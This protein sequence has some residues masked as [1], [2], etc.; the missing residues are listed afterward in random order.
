M[1]ESAQ[2]GYIYCDEAARGDHD[3]E[4]VGLI[5]AKQACAKVSIITPWRSLAL[6]S[7]GLVASLFLAGPGSLVGSAAA[8][9]PAPAWQITATGAPSVLA[10]VLGV[11]GEF[12][13]VVENVGGSDSEGAVVVK[14]VLP[15]GLTVKAVRAVPEE[16]SPV[17]EKAGGEVR[18]T[19]SGAVVPSGFLVVCIEYE[20]TGAVSSLQNLVEVSGGGAASVTAQGNGTRLGAAGETGP[21]GI[22]QF[23]SDVTDVAGEPFEQAG[24]HP[25]LQTTSLLFNDVY[26]EGQSRPTRSVGPVK[27]IVLYLPLGMLDDPAV[28]DPCPASV[29]ETDGCPSSGRVGSVLPLMGDHVEPANTSDST[30]VSALYSVTP[31]LGNTAEFAFTSSG[32]TFFLYA[33]VVRHDGQYVLSVSMPDIPGVA[34]LT[35]LIATFYGDLP[36]RPVGRD[37][38]LTDPSDCGAGQQALAGSVT[39]NTWEDPELALE[40]SSQEFAGIVGCEELSFQAGLEVASQTTQAEAPAGYTVNLTVPQAPSGGSGLATPPIKEVSVTLPAGTS[41]SPAGAEELAT[42]RETGPSGM[43]IEDS[44]SEEVD[45]NGLARPVAGHCPSSSQVG[46]ASA[47]TPLLGE[48]LSGHLFLAEPQCGGP[49]QRACGEEDARDGAL[50]G[51]YLELEGTRSGLLIKLRGR[52]SVDPASGRITI[53]FDDAPQFPLERLTLVTKAGARAPLANPQECGTALSSATLTPWST[54][55]TPPVEPTASFVVDWDGLGRACPASAPFAP[56]LSGGTTSHAAGTTSPFTLGLAREDREQNLSELSATLPAGMLAD[57][58]KVARCPEPQASQAALAACPADSR[59]G[60]ATVVVGSG[61]S[62]YEAA[63][64][65]FLT[66]PYR[67]APFGLSIVIP[68]V[69]GA[70]DLGDI[71]V[72]AAV[73]IDPH[74]AQ[75]TV[76]SDALPQELDGVPLRLRLLDLATSDGELVLNPTGC[77]AQSITGVVQSS[78]GGAVDVSAPFE[79]SE[80]GRLRFAPK[81]SGS[82]DQLATSANGTA[83]ALQMAY[84]AAG[85]ANLASLAIEFPKQLPVRPE[86]LTRAC[87]RAT[88]AAN[89]AQCPAA[90][91]VG[92]AVAHT[93]LLSGAAAGPTYL[94]AGP[95]GSAGIASVLQDEGVTLIV[96]GQL[97]V[98]GGDQ[99]SATFPAVPDVPFSTFETTLP[100][101]SNSLFTSAGAAHVEQAS[102]CGEDLL[103]K[104]AMTAHDGAVVREAPRLSVADCVAPRPSVAILGVRAKRHGL[105]VTVRTSVSGRLRIS[106]RDLRTLMRRGLAAG[107]HTFKVPFTRHSRAAVRH[108][109]MVRIAVVLTVGD[110]HPMAHR[111]A[112][113]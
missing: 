56:T 29:V 82:T 26:L 31:E 111:K 70:F 13:A 108:H 43:N 33:D 25:Y 77:A 95:P 16:A 79:A 75:A 85:Q 69:A 4:L 38:F 71:L 32:Y 113:L 58:A 104:V 73:A 40:A 93:P 28:T 78:T 63:G 8:A 72:R 107:T 37:A 1:T 94:L 51:L 23:S 86:T 109:R 19:Y 74:T 42:C 61:G 91:D 68:A 67:G 89:P 36:E 62:P 88:F 98:L 34:E 27:T 5:Y 76:S 15:A 112:A 96:E 14:D 54:P 84:P 60:T 90:S 47:K 97:S 83:V 59:I 55:T 50:L 39:A 49:G 52:A 103:V 110:T 10:P 41:I 101:Q 100:A 46:T 30:H 106:G 105:A 12:E 102:Q 53:S 66:G 22:A 87:P 99:L 3:W 81:L 45:S 80:C 6:Q 35:G 44:E 9:P 20:V 48:E 18:C 2:I 11:H 92:T 65:V 7:L 57:V 17:C 24:G 64:E 21:A